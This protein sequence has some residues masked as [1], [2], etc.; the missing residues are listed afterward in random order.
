MPQRAQTSCLGRM[1]GALAGCQHPAR[2][3]NILPGQDVWAPWGP[4]GPHGPPW[5]PMGPH[6]R[7]MGAPWAPR[8]RPMGAPWGQDVGQDVGQE[9]WSQSILPRQDVWGPLGPPG[10][11]WGHGGPK[12]LMGAPWGPWCPHGPPW[13]PKGPQGPQTSCLGRMFGAIFPGQHPAL[14]RGLQILW[15]PRAQ[16]GTIVLL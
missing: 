6:G 1:F 16:G 4:M 7:P 2:G 14:S 9:I 5:G 11:P 8:G 15:S 10:A 12:G 13:G 3:P